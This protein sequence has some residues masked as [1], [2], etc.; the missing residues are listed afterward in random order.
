VRIRAP[1]R[2]AARATALASHTRGI[3]SHDRARVI[4]GIQKTLLLVDDDPRNLVVLRALL[5]RFGHRLLH[6]DGGAQAIASFETEAPDLVLCDLAMPRVDGM[7]VLAAIRAHPTRADTPIILL[8]A[9]AEREHRI[10]AL[11]AGADDFLEK[12]I[13]EPVLVARVRTLL[14]LKHS[15][16]ALDTARL[17]LAARH[18]AVER[19]QKEQR[20]LADFILHD[21][22]VP[23]TVLQ[24]SLDWSRANLDADPAARADALEEASVA[25]RRVARM[26]EDLVMVSRLEQPGFPIRWS[27]VRIDTLVE[28]V[29]ARCHSALARKNIAVE[30]EPVRGVEVLADQ[31]LLERVVENLIDN[32]L[33]HTPDGGRVCV[34][35]GIEQGASIVIS[36]DGPPIAAGDRSRIFDKFMRGGTSPRAHSGSVG[37]GLYF[38]KRAMQAQSGDVCLVDVPGWSTSFRVSLRG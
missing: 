21:L 18:A 34:Q 22:K 13:D 9:Y 11:Q 17:E 14:R 36:N 24:L 26:S 23:L 28:Q 30:L 35:T 3:A 1:V 19:L 16:D 29:I 33:R 38:C 32:S 7:A 12:P 31:H 4:R 5:D 8:T 2:S 25:A 37:L 6:A 10:R 20:E 27:R 15:R